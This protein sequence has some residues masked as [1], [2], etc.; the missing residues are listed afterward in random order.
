[1]WPFKKKQSPLPIEWIDRA[2]EV[3][4]EKWLE[5]QNLPFKDGLSLADQI[6]MFSVPLGQGLKT[7]EAFKGA[8]EG[9]FLFIAAKGVQMSGTHT[10]DEIEVALGGL[11]LVD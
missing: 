3:A 7:W 8:T 4:A 11:S 6:Y 5:F 9:A 2:I 1:M 10:R